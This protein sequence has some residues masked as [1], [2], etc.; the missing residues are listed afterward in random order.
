MHTSC[1]SL[2]LLDKLLVLQ[3][4]SCYPVLI[5]EWSKAVNKVLVPI[6][7]DYVN[8]LTYMLLPLYFCLI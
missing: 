7:K 3:M 4:R 8:Y 6:S 2:S 1:Y 5:A